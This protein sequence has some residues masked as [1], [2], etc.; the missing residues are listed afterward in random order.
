M[1]KIIFFRN[2]SK[3]LGIYTGYKIHYLFFGTAWIESWKS[4]GMSEESIENII[5]SAD[6][7]FAPNFVDHDL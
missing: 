1:E 2:I 7:N 5:K 3:L 4:N 6:S